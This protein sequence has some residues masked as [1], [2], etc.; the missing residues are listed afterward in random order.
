MSQKKPR[1]LQ[2]AAAFYQSLGLHTLRLWG[3]LPGGGCA[4]GRPSCAPR[5]AGKHPVRNSWQNTPPDLVFGYGENLGLRCGLQPSGAACVAFDVDEPEAF[6]ALQAQLGPLPE[7]L[8]TETGRG[9]HLIFQV[10]PALL[11]LLKNFVKRS[12]VDLR[13]EGGQVVAAPS[14]HY[15]G[16]SYLLSCAAAPAWLPWR[17][18]EWLVQ[19]SAARPQEGVQGEPCPLPRD[20]RWLPFARALVAEAT[21]DFR[22]SSGLT[23]KL[24]VRLVRG[25]CLTREAAFELLQVFNAASDEPLPVEKLSRAVVQAEAASELP[26]GFARPMRTGSLNAAESPADLEPRLPALPAPLAAPPPE[27]PEFSPKARRQKDLTRTELDELG[28][29]RGAKPAL[30]RLA[31]AANPYSDIQEFGE[32]LKVLARAQPDGFEWAA[33]S[34][35]GLLEKC[36]VGG[37]VNLAQAWE[38]VLASLREGGASLLEMQTIFHGH[39]AWQSTLGW[40]ELASRMTWRKTPPFT[41]AAGD[42]VTDADV[43]GVRTWFEKEFG[44]EP[45]KERTWDAM[46]GFSTNHATFNPLQDRL[47]ALRWDGVPRLDGWLVRAAGA[48]PTEFCTLAGSK[49]LISAIARAFKPGCKV[50]H[51]LVLQGAAQGEGKS[52]AFEILALEDRWF[53]ALS[54]ELSGKDAKELLRGKWLVCFDELD[55]LS[56]SERSSVKAFVTARHDDYRPA[57]G[58]DTVQYPRR[59]AFGGTVN[60]FEFLEDDPERRWWPVAVKTVD[61]IWL[62]ANREQLWAEAKMR[63]DAGSDWWTIPLELRLA[64]QAPFKSEDTFQTLVEEWLKRCPAEQRAP[65]KLVNCLAGIGQEPT[66]MRAQKRV[67]HALRKLG[68]E[69]RK[70]GDGLI[71]WNRPDA[72]EQPR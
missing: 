10:L 29:K 31:E 15:S 14:L 7:T 66:D 23:W 64:A 16:R 20:D 68:C 49:W 32:A 72:S 67:A 35:A 70:D 45:S 50:D 27:P 69:K 41:R 51:A 13:A 42:N 53:L 54:N 58:H 5:S 22:G 40:D 65:F 28:L 30:K 38:G 6:A 44:A 12:G 3:V 11:P 39:R 34:V 56:R 57:Y 46:Q 9:F 59:C 71:L 48:A 19:S 47:N 61:R 26:W 21:P 43:I 60:D 36:W 33:G 62:A 17:W 55:A 52:S 2:Q 1:N 8:R 18:V 25:L 4:C 37:P 24:A 63:F